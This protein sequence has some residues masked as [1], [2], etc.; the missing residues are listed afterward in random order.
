M[1]CSTGSHPFAL[2]PG[3]QVANEVASLSRAAGPVVKK[4]MMEPVGGRKQ[5]RA[6]KQAGTRKSCWSETL[7]WR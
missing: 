1:R 2:Q 7:V 3:P 4:W 5:T 6:R